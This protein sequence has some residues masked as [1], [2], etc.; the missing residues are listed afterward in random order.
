[1]K[2]EYGTVVLE[3]QDYDKIQASLNNGKSIQAAFEIEL[4]ENGIS[5]LDV[6]QIQTKLNITKEQIEIYSKIACEVKTGR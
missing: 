4:A 5:I 1:M 2:L 3:K 6:Y